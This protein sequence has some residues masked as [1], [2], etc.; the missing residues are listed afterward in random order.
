MTARP[1]INSNGLRAIMAISAT[2][3]SSRLLLNAAVG[4]L[5]SGHSI[6]WIA[7]MPSTSLTE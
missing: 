3:L 7:G 4:W 1:M 6:K 5:D 2:L